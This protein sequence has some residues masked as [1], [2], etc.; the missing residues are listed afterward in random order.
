V[1]LPHGFPFELVDRVDGPT[2]RVRL[3]AGAWWARGGEPMLLGL[4]VEAGAQA[5]AVLLG[6]AGGPAAG[7][8]IHLAAIENATCERLPVAGEELELRARATARYG[9][10]TRIE[11]E[12]ARDG[13]RI[14]GATL[15][16]SESGS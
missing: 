12:L 16:V 9:R 3:T 13:V 8:A 4:L 10:T 14:G 6:A 15:V 7:A 5:A 2:A 1:S 11:V